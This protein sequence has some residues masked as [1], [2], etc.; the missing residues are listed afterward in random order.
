MLSNHISR[1]NRLRTVARGIITGQA[2]KCNIAS[3]GWVEGRR[4][5]VVAIETPGT[6]RRRLPAK[7]HGLRWA[8]NGIPLAARK[9]AG[10]D[11]ADENDGGSGN[12]HDNG[13]RYVDVVPLVGDCEVEA[14]C[15]VD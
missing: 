15:S 11:V 3:R 12:D 7:R 4:R 10:D 6:S 9:A 8:N 13:E 1:L 14:D 5:R 2:I